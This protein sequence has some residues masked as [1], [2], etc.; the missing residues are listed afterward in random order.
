[1]SKVKICGLSRI[2]DIEAVN[3]VLPDFIGF[4]FASGRRKVD[5]YTATKLK[6][7]LDPRI[8]AVGVFVN[9]AVETVAEIYNNKIID[10]AQLHGDEDGEYIRQLRSLCGCGII[11]TVSISAG[12]TVSA[13]IGAVST[14]SDRSNSGETHSNAGDGFDWFL[15]SQSYDADFLLFDTLTNQRG[16]AGKVFDWNI[17]KQYSG[18]PY[19]LAGGLTADNVTDAINLLNPFCVDVS[20]G[21]ETDGLKDEAKIRDFIYK[22]RQLN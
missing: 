19:F 8:K 17:L 11:K 22:V 5:M 18:L 3:R 15:P 10:L 21:V 2:E 20:S 4:V 12:T 1:M 7:K 6:E 13:N 9:E 16:G 14:V